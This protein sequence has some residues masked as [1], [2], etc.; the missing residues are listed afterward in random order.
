MSDI[1]KADPVARKKAAAI[2]LV[3]GGIGVLIL[4]F[5]SI[6]ESAIYEWLDKNIQ[7]LISHSILVFSALFIFF[8]PLIFFA[9]YLFKFSNLVVLGQ[10]MP[11]KDYPVVRDTKVVVGSKAI[12]RG[13][14]LQIFALLLV[15]F[16]VVIPIS[17]T[18]IFKT[19]ISTF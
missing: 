2:A 12:L 10:R 16:S 7:F 13:R 18:Y 1:Q 17:I 9:A 8:V 14:I 5:G 6:Y 3:F 15:L 11:P 4:L 19:L